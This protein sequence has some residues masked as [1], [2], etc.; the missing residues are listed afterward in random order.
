VELRFGAG[1]GVFA[2]RRRWPRS[3]QS[4]PNDGSFGS[5]STGDKS[6]RATVLN[7][8][9]L[10]GPVRRARRSACR[11]AAD[12]HHARTRAGENTSSAED[13]IRGWRLLAAGAEARRQLEQ[14]R[15]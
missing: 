15:A 13:Q 9:E 1:F 5:A 4:A 3:P 6:R 11:Q 14:P 12:A 8:G 2:P 10:R 7:C